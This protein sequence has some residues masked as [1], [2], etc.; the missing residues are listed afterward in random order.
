LE[1][2]PSN[3]DFLPSW[4]KS[5]SSLEE[6]RRISLEHIQ[7]VLHHVKVVAGDRLIAIGVVSELTHNPY[8]NKPNF[9]RQIFGITRLDD[10]SG[11]NYQWLINAYQIARNILPNAKLYYSDFLIEFGGNKSEEVYNFISTLRSRGAPI[12]AVAFQMHLQGSDLDS[13]EE[14]N[15]NTEKLRQQIRRYQ[16]I[17]VEVIVTELDIN[18]REVG[19]PSTYR[20]VVQARAYY[21]I[22]RALIE[23]GV[24]TIIF[25]NPV[26]NQYNWLEQ[27]NPNADPTLYNEDGTPKPAFYSVLQALF[28]N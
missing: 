22:V 17:G 26:D 16:Q 11:D 2:L 9:W 27:M 19:G 14:L 13:P 10:L 7:N 6:V 24:D 15:L 4:L 5:E 28:D 1:L 12:D 21:S 3:S 8:A 18:M 20:N 25:F 23:E